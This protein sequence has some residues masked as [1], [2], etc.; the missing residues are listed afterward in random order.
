MHHRA[1]T[2]LAIVAVL[3]AFPPAHVLGQDAEDATAATMI[4]AD[5][6]EF[7]PIEI[8]GFDSGMEIA[9]MFGDFTMEGPYTLRISMP[10]GYRFPA[11]FHPKDENLTVISGTFLLA[12]GD[13]V[14]ESQLVSYGPGDFMNLPAEH[15][16]Y[17]G[18]KGF[19]VIQLH[20]DG[21][22]EILL[23]EETAATDGS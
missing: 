10:D 5:D 3:L 20:G 14:D 6:L 21:P 4:M 19:T 17:G 2:L 12:M 16:H 15:P 8:P 18:A 13:W 7:A 1:A 11:H 22:F 23:V 9:G